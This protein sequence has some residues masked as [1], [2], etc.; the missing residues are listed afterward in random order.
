MDRAA[1]VADKVREMD[2][3]AYHAR[4][5]TQPGSCGVGNEMPCQHPNCIERAATYSAYWTQLAARCAITLE[6]LLT[7]E[8]ERPCLRK[9]VEC[10]ADEGARETWCVNCQQRKGAEP[11]HLEREMTIDYWKARAEELQARLTAEPEDEHYI[12]E[13]D[14]RRCVDHPQGDH[15]L[16]CLTCMENGAEPKRPTDKHPACRCDC[17]NCVTGNHHQCYYKPSVCSAQAGAEPERPTRHGYG[18]PHDGRVFT[19]PRP[20]GCDCDENGVTPAM[21]EK[22]AEPERQAPECQ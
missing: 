11:E 18:C 2:E 22:A 21:R 13:R 14:G 3:A 12:P 9:Y 17:V 7:A 4:S 10:S 1:L 8:P 6:S 16:V 20:Y 5:W 19:D 15:E